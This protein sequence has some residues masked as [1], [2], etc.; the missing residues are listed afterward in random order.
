MRTA[1]KS[2]EPAAPMPA[3]F[4]FQEAAKSLGQQQSCGP[5]VAPSLSAIAEVP[6]SSNADC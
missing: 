5:V 4:S 6:N 3:A 2:G 1:K